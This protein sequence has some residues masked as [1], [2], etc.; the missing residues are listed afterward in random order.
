[1]C[2]QKL[3]K[4]TVLMMLRSALLAPTFFPFLKSVR[5]HLRPLLR[6]L[7]TCKV[8]VELKVLLLAPVQLARHKRKR[9]KDLYF[10]GPVFMK[11][12]R[13]ALQNA[14]KSLSNVCFLFEARKQQLQV[15][16]HI[17]IYHDQGVIPKHV[18][19]GGIPCFCNAVTKHPSRLIIK[20]RPP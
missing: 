14:L 1:M 3:F 6:G 20:L 15:L 4:C 13:I 16:L 19:E 11:L 7:F 18:S 8:G 2:G 9:N 5:S 10:S 12:L 17:I